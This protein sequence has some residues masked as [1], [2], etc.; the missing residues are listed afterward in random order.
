MK[1]FRNEKAKS[2]MTYKM[3][4]FSNKARIENIPDYIVSIEKLKQTE[5]WLEQKCKTNKLVK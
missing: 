3:D 4:P 1:V 5:G 2:R